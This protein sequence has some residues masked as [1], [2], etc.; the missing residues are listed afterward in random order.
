MQNANEL[1]RVENLLVNFPV[2]VPLFSQ[3]KYVHAVS[4]VSLSI[5]RGETFGLVG[6]SGCGKTTL[7]HAILGMIKP[8]AGS[9][10]FDNKN[11][12]EVSKKE[13]FELRKGMQM[14]F[15]DPFSSLNPRFDVFNI[16]AEPMIIR[17][18]YSKEDIN[19]RVLELLDYVG[20][21]Q[22]DLYRYPSE[23]SG[24]QRQRL[25]IARAIALNPSFIVCDEPVSALDVSIHSQILNLLMD[26]QKEFKLTYLF[27]SHNLAVVKHMCDTIVVMY[28]GEVVEIGKSDAIFNNPLHPYTKALLSAVMD[29]D[30]DNK[31]DR[32]MLSGEIPSPI[33]PPEGCRFSTRCSEAKQDCGKN[34][35]CLIE[36]EKDH[37]V[38]CH[39]YE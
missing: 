6:E 33:D 29:I 15:Q 17:G 28:L 36:I 18:S 1:I 7:A 13:F 12:N 16:V 24:G 14:V 26:L 22:K 39:Q 2:K 11:I 5:K 34:K 32:I 23:F 19:K 9:V 31:N 8:T 37:Y 35:T 27:V 3:K 4:D 10:Y 21:S 20:L 30:I 38:A 25:G